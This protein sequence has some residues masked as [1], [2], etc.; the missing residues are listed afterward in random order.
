MS[1]KNVTGDARAIVTYLTEHKGQHVPIMWRRA[2]KTR[3][4]VKE[5][6]EKQTRAY[7]RAGIEYANL[8]SV[9]EGIADGTRDEVGSLP[10]W[11]EWAAKPFILRH[12]ENG[13]EYVRLYPATFDNLKP[14][15]E[16][17]VN[18]ALV[19]PETVKPLCLASEFRE[20][21]TPTEVF[22]VKANDILSI[23]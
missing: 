22:Q 17:Y 1:A 4:D 2:M 6:V 14:V 18:G 3:K 15:V 10:V 11:Q 13:T 12:K 19:N 20:R 21:D 16:Y 9:K 23:G 7:V 5:K 8:A